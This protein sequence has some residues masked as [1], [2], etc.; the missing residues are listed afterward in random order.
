MFTLSTYSNL[1]L[2][3]LSQYFC[4]LSMSISISIIENIFMLFLRVYYN[5]TLFMSVY[6]NLIT[7][8]SL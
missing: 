1:Y 5:L 4:P 8:I 2:I 7:Y 6:N 3:Y